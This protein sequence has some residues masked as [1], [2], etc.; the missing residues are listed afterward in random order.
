MVKRLPGL[1]ALGLAL[2]LA[3]ASGAS[4]AEPVKI[5]LVLP[6]TGP[7]AD[8]IGRQVL[9]GAQLYM[10]EH[11]DTIAG[12][13]IE[14]L[15]KD[16]T[17][18]P[19]ITKRIVQEAIVSDHADILAG[20]GLTPL[21][22][23]AAPVATQ[24]KVP[25]IVMAAATSSITEQSPFIVRTSFTLPQV[26]APIADWA[27]ANAI[28]TV[29]TLVSDYGPGIDAENTFKER[30]TRAGGEIVGSIRAPL[31]NPEF[32]PY[33]QRVKDL[34]PDAVFLFVPNGQNGQLMRQLAERE[35]DKAG[36]KV[37]ATGDVVD[38]GA[39]NAIG[40][41][42]LGM[43][44]SHH[45]SVAHDSPENKAFVAAFKTMAGMRPNMMG[46]GGYDGMALIY[47]ALQKTGGV[48]D[49]PALVEAMKG[50]SWQSPRGPVQIDPQTRDI[51][52][53]VYLRKV[54]K[55]DG[56]LYN[57]EFFKIGAVKDPGKAA[58]P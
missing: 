5:A 20:F 49:G 45:Y 57:V 18:A 44:T 8:A 38:D 13:K 58:K 48:A 25:M 31:R 29:A 1:A 55:R 47:A 46:V 43:I 40:D 19:E 28:H 35:F 37:I 52:Q 33:L 21:A 4:A 54:E 27:A 32:A 14:L 17:G 16:D 6:L 42:A 36:I 12:R 7:F 39:I 2:L 30:F 26:T 53:D 50:M 51:I 9:T 15:I 24:A 56:E 34:S 41:V 23:T 22:L 10:K 11:G 3:G